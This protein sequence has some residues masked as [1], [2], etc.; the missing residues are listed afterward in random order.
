MSD[1]L[2]RLVRE[3]VRD[4]L[5][6]RG[7]LFS[8]M[9]RVPTFLLQAGDEEPRGIE[10]R[11]YRGGEDFSI[12][13]DPDPGWGSLWVPMFSSPER[14]AEFVE[15][16]EPG[17]GGGRF[18]QWAS[19][20]PNEIY[21][22]LQGT[23]R[24]AGIRLDPTVQ[25]GLRI[26][27]PEVESLSGGRLP[28]PGPA[29]HRGDGADYRV[30]EG[31]RCA[32]S[33]GTKPIDGCDARQIIFPDTEGL[34][35]E[36]FRRLAE[37]DSSGTGKAWTPCRHFAAMLRGRAGAGDAGGVRSLVRC[38]V[39]FELFGEAEGY[40]AGLAGDPERS[41]YAAGALSTILLRTGQLERCIEVCRRG[42]EEHP[43]ERPLYL[44]WARAHAQTE[45]LEA[46]RDVA[47]RGMARFPED[48][49][50]RK[51]L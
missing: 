1:E 8:A 41:A 35:L 29:L 4:P 30:P 5:A 6:D 47:R 17:A 16:L 42:I 9:L 10:T 23:P 40:C 18:F 45:D 48:P 7:E 25:G 46:A 38:L 19:H 31:T 15:R 22:S 27:W 26:D 11:S 33:R 13:A 51:F 39:D 21:G 44:N 14:V 2:G 34:I 49:G 32:L 12:W 24:F 3:A 36:D 43:E 28:P 20:L 37:V 50:L